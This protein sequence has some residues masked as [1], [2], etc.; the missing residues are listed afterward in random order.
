[1]SAYWYRGSTR[2]FEVTALD[3]LAISILISASLAREPNQRG[4]YW[5]AGLGVMLFYFLYCCGAVALAEPKIFGLFELS[6]ILRGILF[7]LAAAI[8]VRSERELGILV[9]A[10]SSA[11]CF[12]GVLCLKQRFLSG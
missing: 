8:Y 4:W 11:I 6:K 3:V 10:L 12:E 7:F 2:G 9:F 5:P 1:A